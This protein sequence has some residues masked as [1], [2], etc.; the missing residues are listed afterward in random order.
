MATTGRPAAPFRKNHVLPGNAGNAI[1]SRFLFFDCEAILG[2][3][4]DDPDVEN[5]T[6]Q[7]GLMRFVERGRE[8]VKTDITTRFT[9]CSEFWKEVYTR[10]NPKKLLY[11][12]AHNAAYDLSIVRMIDEIAE[13][14]LI[15]RFTA[16]QRGLFI[17][18]ADTSNGPVALL[19]TMNYWNCSLK[20]LGDMIGLPKL[21]MPAIA[22]DREDWNS[23]CIR[24]V[25]IITKAIL[26]LVRFVKDHDLGN[27]KFTAASQSFA[28][29]RHRFMD[30]K[31]VIH[32]HGD[33]VALERKAFRAGRCSIFYYGDIHQ[34]LFHIDCNSLYPHVMQ[35]F[36]YPTRLVDHDRF[37]SLSDERL[38][39]TDLAAIARVKLQTKDTE[40]PVWRN[41]RVQYAT[42]SFVAVLAEPELRQAIENDEVIEIGELCLYEKA[43]IFRRYIQWCLE[44][45]HYEREK[46][47]KALESI[48]KLMANSLFGKFGQH[49]Y[50]WIEQED[51]WNAFGDPEITVV[52]DGSPAGYTLRQLGDKLEK[53]TKDTEGIDSFPAICACVTSYGRMYMDLLRSICGPRTVLLQ[54]VDSLLVT[55]DGFNRLCGA[56]LIEDYR[57]GSMKIENV[58]KSAW[59]WSA[60]D[61]QLDAQHRICGIP[62][63]AKEIDDGVFQFQQ[64]ETA[65]TLFN[66]QMKGNVIVRKV[67][68]TL[69][70]PLPDVPVGK[71]GWLRKLEL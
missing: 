22:S 46:G 21:E 67:E 28:A 64:F 13:G 8:K 49:G 63:R 48:C 25:E 51:E 61:Y 19:D 27:F 62:I 59:L 36:Q 39:R 34:K 42:G 47:S 30:E 7:F 65:N 15:P 31:I 55:E 69:S 50:E 24:D 44:Q 23:Y 41:D 9:E 2:K 70:R 58:H 54:Y 11:V 56:G 45:R 10:C 3:D 29:Y 53:Q 38:R 14:R 43:P 4:A 66:Q 68:R 6:L 60:H 71:D 35:E 16:T 33:A 40:Y 20:R 26:T 1:P 17:L 12:Y 5:Q 32:G 18:S 57:P 37:V 52:T